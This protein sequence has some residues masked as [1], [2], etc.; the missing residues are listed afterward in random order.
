MQ[1][2]KKILVGLK[3][4]SMD[5]EL[6]E[7][8]SRLVDISEATEV[9]FIHT[10]KINLPKEIRESFPKLEQTALG[11]RQKTIE[12]VVNEHF[13][14]T[15][16]VDTSTQVIASVNKLKG[17]VDAI[18]KLDI[19]LTIV[20]R[21]TIR[22]KHSVVIQRL[23]RR[24]PCQLLIVPEGTINRID[25]ND[26]LHKFLVPVD[27]SEYSELA[28]ERA[29]MMGARNNQNNDVEIVCQHVYSVPSGYHYTGKTKKEFAEIMKDN[30]QATFDEWI[31]KFDT[32]GVKITPVLS[33]DINEDKTSDMKDLAKEIDADCIVI[34]SKGSTAAVA[35][36]MGSTAEK[37]VKN[38]VNFTL[39]VVRKKGDYKGIIEQIRKL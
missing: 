38:M 1:P 17:V 32:K 34:G 19:D 27:F 3:N 2:I 13:H 33:E 23:A 18:G 4:T 28:L 24:A 6:I 25:K 16:E 11:D 36:F 22:S 20:G 10:V 30:A 29:I 12:A 8:V 39:M 21:S 5:V 26:I 37:L 9:H 7:Y 31:Q 35:L 15:R 14:P